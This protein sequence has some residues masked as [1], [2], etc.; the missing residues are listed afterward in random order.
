MAHSTDS[1][2]TNGPL[3]GLPHMVAESVFVLEISYKRPQDF[4]ALLLTS[5]G[6][7]L[8]LVWQAMAHF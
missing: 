8:A 6:T 7:R 3:G 4:T 5:Q 1:F 2:L